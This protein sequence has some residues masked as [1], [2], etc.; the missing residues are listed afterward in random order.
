MSE[1]L[2][3]ASLLADIVRATKPPNVSDLVPSINALERYT[4][5]GVP[6]YVEGTPDPVRLIWRDF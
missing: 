3:L 4:L 2:T 1:A 6:P 5:K